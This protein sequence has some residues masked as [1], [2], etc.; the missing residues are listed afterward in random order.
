MEAH[1]KRISICCYTN[2]CHRSKARRKRSMHFY[3]NKNSL[4]LRGG[5]SICVAK[6]EY[7]TSNKK[8]IVGWAPQAGVIFRFAP[9]LFLK[10]MLQ[11]I[12]SLPA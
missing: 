5:Y 6:I 12:S 3:R 1:E 7:H 4:L 2:L 10:L 9:C 8:S 11:Y